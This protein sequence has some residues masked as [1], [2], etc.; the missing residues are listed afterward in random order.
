MP[1]RT[2]LAR[3]FRPS[4]T[5]A[6]VTVWILLYVP[7]NCLWA[8]DEAPN[9]RE[10]TAVVVL[11]SRDVP[12][13]YPNF[14]RLRFLTAAGREIGTVDR[15]P[16]DETI[17]GNHRV[18]VDKARARVYAAD[19]SGRVIATDHRGTI[20]WTVDGSAKSLAVDPQTGNVWC[21]MGR[22]LG[23][24]STVVLDSDGRKIA[25]LPLNGVDI[26]YG[27]VADS[28]WIVGPQ[29]VRVTRDREVALRRPLPE[30]HR[31]PNAPAI[32][33][34]RNWTAVSVAPKPAQEGPPPHSKGA[35]VAV[36]AHPDVPG[37]LNRLVLFNEAGEAKTLIELGEV[38]PLAVA[39][40]F[41]G[42][43]WVVDRQQQLLRFNLDGQ[44]TATLPVPAVAIGFG[45]KGDL[46]W[47]TTAT[48]V[49]CLDLE[50]TEKAR[51]RF[52]SRSAQSWLAAF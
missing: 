22:G 44:Q 17:A 32:V 16:N 5:A 2:N 20:Q 35:W 43:A 51:Y 37:S 39:A 38:D 25:D 52:P 30:V 13:E 42:D 31:E 40:D 11:D 7:A 18:A 46:L 21:L 48:E 26:A 10:A 23:R 6:R 9:G 50:G 4:R 36:R 45:A 19:L 27:S 8:W 14:S 3:R 24:G 41:Q 29:V 12:K 49:L 34:G 33:N 28:F 47:T 15:L 1:I